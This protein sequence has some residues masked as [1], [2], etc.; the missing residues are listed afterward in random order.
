MA[1]KSPET[2]STRGYNISKHNV[3]RTFLLR[4][5]RDGKRLVSRGKRVEMSGVPE[6]QSA[7]T[8]VSHLEF[9]HRTTVLV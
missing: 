3:R 8:V 1:Q 4:M 7:G 5:S 9:I 2:L 6:L